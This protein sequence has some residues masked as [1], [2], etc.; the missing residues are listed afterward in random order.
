MGSLTLTPAFSPA[1]TEYTTS[2]TN[3]SNKLTAVAED[4]D[5]VITV[6]L[7][8]ETVTDMTLTWETGENE[9]EVKVVN[10]GTSKT[11]TVTVT[12]S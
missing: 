10:G 6:K 9:V 2:T 11:Y 1:V 3:A 7:N 5:S 12:A 8:D 4:P